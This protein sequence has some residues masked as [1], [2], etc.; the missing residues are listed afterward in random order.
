M[1]MK[2]MIVMW[3]V[4]LGVGDGLLPLNKNVES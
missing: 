2:M 3:L 1:M 4:F